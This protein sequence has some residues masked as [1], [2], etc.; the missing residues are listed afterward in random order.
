MPK[1]T[2]PGATMLLAAL[3]VVLLF[4]LA[5][6]FRDTLRGFAE[7]FDLRAVRRFVRRPRQVAI[8]IG[9]ILGVF[10]LLWLL[11]GGPGESLYYFVALVPLICIPGLTLIWLI[12]SDVWQ[13]FHDLR[14]RDRRK[15]QH[16]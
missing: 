8:T 1:L 9:V 5:F 3:A 12:V 10:V 7:F 4:A 14:K 16:K 2:G 15:R 11:V 6:S 13:G